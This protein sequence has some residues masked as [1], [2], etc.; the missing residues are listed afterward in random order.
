MCVMIKSIALWRSVSFFVSLIKWFW[1]VLCGV[2]CI[3]WQGICLQHELLEVTQ[4]NDINHIGDLKYPSTLVV[5]YLLNA[6]F[7]QHTCRYPREWHKQRTVLR[8]VSS[9]GQSESALNIQAIALSCR[10]VP[11]QL[12]GFTALPVEKY[13][14][15]WTML[16][17]F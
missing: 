16:V 15:W 6:S 5:D 13:L 2:L 7:T 12:S 17:S 9:S 8:Y 14:S 1:C 10:A 3:A 4:Q 11:T